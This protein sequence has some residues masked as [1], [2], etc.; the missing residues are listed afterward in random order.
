MDERFYVQ[1]SYKIGQHVPA[2]SKG[3]DWILRQIDQVGWNVSL[4]TQEFS[5]LHVFLGT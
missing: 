3:M 5:D 4:N 1:K 2:E